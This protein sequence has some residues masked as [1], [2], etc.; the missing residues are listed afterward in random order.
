MGALIRA[1][2]ARRARTVSLLFVGLIASGGAVAQSPVSVVI[3]SP[4]PR[5]VLVGRIV[6]AAEVRPA[7][8]EVTEVEFFVDG[9]P[10]CTVKMPPY[11]CTWNAGSNVRPR[12]V[13]AVARRPAGPP[14]A[15]AMRTRGMVVD[16]AVDV[17]AVVVSVRVTDR[18]GRFVPGLTRED[19]RLV[20]DGV[21]QDVAGFR[22]EDAGAEV[23]IALD[24]S[25]SMVP[26]LGEVRS[27]TRLFLEALRPQD[28]VT[29]AAFSA[30][31]RVVA[32]PSLGLAERRARLDE[33]QPA[34]NTALYDA[35]VRASE[36]FADSGQ[37]AV[38]VFTDGVD[39]VS[40]SSMGSV[41]TA[42]QSADVGLYVL[43]Q[44]KAASDS[45][46]RSRLTGLARETG[47]AAYFSSRLSALHGQFAA[48]ADDIA[49]RYVLSFT[50]ARPLGDG[51]WRRLEVGLTDPALQH[52][53]RARE[54][55][56]ALRRRAKTP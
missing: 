10:V 6:L 23:V 17:D 48:I 1:G 34:G 8:T 37:R 11:R 43:A 45:G 54:G 53:V 28:A 56:L 55:Y 18:N 29:L 24:M 30:N 42:L 27:A 39:V 50:P 13:R 3:T 40:R 15:T 19:F 33:L 21:P 49:H 26:A 22:A 25:G 44:G 38:V 9:V 12:A 5:M 2:R 36:L 7:T 46:L 32:A 16:D 14:V 41:R 47:G 51:A 35:M 4:S 52:T 31:L 20:E